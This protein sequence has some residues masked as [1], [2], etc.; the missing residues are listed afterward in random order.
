MND[1]AGQSGSLLH[2]G[3]SRSRSSGPG[4]GGSMDTAGRQR[5]GWAKS[6]ERPGSQ[7]QWSPEC[8]GPKVWPLCRLGFCRGTAKGE[9]A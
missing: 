4:V 9:G 1:L 5:E 2:G 7:S 8:H 6:R 3:D